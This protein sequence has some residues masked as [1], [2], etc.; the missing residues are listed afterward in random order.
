MFKKIIIIGLLILFI[1]CLLISQK[2]VLLRPD[3]T[4][5]EIHPDQLKTKQE[6]LV[7]IPV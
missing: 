5:Q 3:G 1:P 2:T 6:I 7:D 4:M